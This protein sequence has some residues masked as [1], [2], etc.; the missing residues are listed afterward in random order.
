[1]GAV[2]KNPPESAS[3]QRAVRALQGKTTEGVVPRWEKKK[4]KSCQAKTVYKVLFTKTC[5]PGGW[6]PKASRGGEKTVRTCFLQE[7]AN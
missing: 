3:L 4:K 5:N 6:S 1:M 2:L 7:G